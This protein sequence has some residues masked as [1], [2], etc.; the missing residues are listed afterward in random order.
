[1]NEWDNWI[2]PQNISATP[3]RRHLLHNNLLKF[4]S[5]ILADSPCTMEIVTSLSL[6]RWIHDMKTAQIT[7]RNYASQ[8]RK[9][10]CIYMTLSKRSN[11]VYHKHINIY[12]LIII[13]KDT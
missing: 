3:I 12:R 2:R 1:M 10:P 11:D 5:V 6:T 4:L 9:T 13:E 7:Q 8:K